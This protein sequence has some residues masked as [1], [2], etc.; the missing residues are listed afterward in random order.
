[1]AFVPRRFHPFLSVFSAEMSRSALECIP[2][3]IRF[4]IEVLPSNLGRN[5]HWDGD[6]RVDSP[7]TRVAPWERFP[8]PG[9]FE[10]PGRSSDRNDWP[11]D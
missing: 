5:H 6:C 10:R 8:A 7:R 4:L 11:S 3:I 9:G 1:M 2:A